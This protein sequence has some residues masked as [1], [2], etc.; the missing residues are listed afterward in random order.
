MSLIQLGDFA[1]SVSTLVYQELQRQA[2]VRWSK[3]QIVGATD[4]LQ[5]TGI[6]SDT[7]KLTGDFHPQ[8]AAWFD[9]TVG[10]LSLDTLRATMKEQ[11]PLL[12]VSADGNSMG[13]WVIESVENSNTRFSHGTGSTPRKQAFNIGLRFFGDAPDSVAIPA[14]QPRAFFERVTFE[15][16]QAER[17]QVPISFGPEETQTTDASPRR[18]NFT[19][20]KSTF[21]KIERV[22]HRQREL[23]APEPALV[24][25]GRLTS[26]ISRFRSDVVRSAESIQR[27][28]KSEIRNLQR[29]ADTGTAY[30]L[31]DVNAASLGMWAL[32][33]LPVNRP[34]RRR[35]DPSSFTVSLCWAGL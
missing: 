32:E 16:K 24:R 30:P 17:E 15:R 3:Q 31:R 35:P 26:D 6:G 7:I 14:A 8:I 29:I 19:I 4:R 12:I 5:A 21:S 2:S 9:G 28:L 11:Q 27:E 34:T 10:T 33:D 25:V 20:P 22:S 13:Y 23:P 18:A 1:F